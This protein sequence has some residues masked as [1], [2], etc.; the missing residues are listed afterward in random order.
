MTRFEEIFYL[1]LIFLA[2]LILGVQ[3]GI[4]HGKKLQFEDI[5]NDYEYICA[6]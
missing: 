5:R 4:S 1:F 6:N 2:V 3:I